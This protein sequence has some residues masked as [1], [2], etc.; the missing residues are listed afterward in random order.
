MKLNLYDRFLR[1][2]KSEEIS[3]NDLINVDELI[4][5]VY[6]YSI[7]FNNILTKQGKIIKLNWLEYNLI[8]Y[9]FQTYNTFILLMI[10][11]STNYFFS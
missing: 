3:S 9:E 2:V 6:L 4:P 1:N 5:G 8:N 11:F 10:L 7:E